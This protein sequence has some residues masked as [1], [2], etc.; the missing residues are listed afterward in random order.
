MPPGR[1]GVRY[2]QRITAH[3]GSRGV[4][5]AADDLAFYREVS[6]ARR[7]RY[8]LELGNERGVN[9]DNVP[10]RQATSTSCVTYS[11]N[12]LDRAVITAHGYVFSIVVCAPIYMY[13]ISGAR[14]R[15]NISAHN[16]CDVGQD[17]AMYAD[18]SALCRIN[19]LASVRE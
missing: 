7:R 10:G 1:T 2:A 4:R 13:R 17:M 19:R 6:R 9:N 8:P 12:C 15:R 14:R 16:P 3:I 18:M 11:H 5:H